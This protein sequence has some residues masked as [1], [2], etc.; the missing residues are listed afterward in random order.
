[1]IDLN[2]V[3]Y[4]YKSGTQALEGISAE[5]GAGIHLLLGENG[6]GKTTLLHIM[7]G[8]LFPSTGTC[9]L[10]GEEI[11]KREP[12]VLRDIFFIT[13]DMK[14]PASTI[15]EFKRIHAPFYPTF[16]DETLTRNLIDFGMNGNEQLMKMSLGTRKK[17][18]LAYA[19]A[20]H[21][22]I[23]LLD[24][25]ANGLDI[26]SK[27]TLQAMMSRCIDETQ[28]VVVSTHTVSDLQHLYDSIIVLSKGR[29]MLSRP[30]WEITECIAFVDTQIPPVNSLYCE[31]E[32]GL[33]R[34][35]I[36]NVEGLS[37]DINY[38]L[39]YS[40]LHSPAC[41]KIINAINNK[42]R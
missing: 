15:N 18:Q 2:N 39:L 36:E 23:L 32:F 13:D 21:T 27:K 42:E 31:Q 3:S 17:A 4:R 38:Q 30:T 22:P 11:R 41:H 29:L 33:F 20:L 34:S 26:T 40:A 1:M 14:Y 6:A 25:P 5:I 9:T 24:E 10:D 28:T 19:L 12:S 7:A 8:L 16:D 35:I 37:T